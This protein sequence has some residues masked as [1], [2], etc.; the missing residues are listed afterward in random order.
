[1]KKDKLSLHYQDKLE[2]QYD[3]ID[4]FVINGYIPKLQI[5]GGFRNWYRDFNGDDKDLTQSRLIKFAGRFSRRIYA[6]AQKKG[7]PIIECKAEQRKHEI[8]NEHLPKDKNSNGLFLILKSRASAFIWEI[9]TSKSGSINIKRKQSFVNHYFFHIMDEKWGHV[10]I[11]MC[12]HPPFN[13]MIILNGHE[14]TERRLVKKNILFEKTDNCFTA[15]D[16]GETLTQVADTCSIGQLEGVCNRWI[17]GCLWFGV[18]Y[19]DQQRT[20]LRYKYSIYQVEYSRN[21]LF[22]R[23]SELDQVY[24]SVIDQTR[25]NLNVERIKTMFGKKSRPHY[26][27]SGNSALQ[28]RIEIPDYNLTVFKIHFGALTLKL[29]DKGERTLRAEVVVHNTKDLKCKRGLEHF[30]TICKKLKTIMQSFLD[31]L[32][33][34]HVATIA[35]EELQQ[36][37]NCQKAGKQKIS[38]INPFKKMDIWVMHAVMAVCFKP[39]GF[40]TGDVVQKIKKMYGVNLKSTQVAYVLRKLKAKKVILSQEGKRKYL[41]SPNGL[42]KILSMIVITEQQLPKVLAQSNNNDVLNEP[43]LKKNYRDAYF[44]L[45]NSIK[46]FIKQSPI[47]IAA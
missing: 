32:L 10:T 19:N 11:R 33:Y 5:P 1:M 45:K 23:G 2:D 4:R 26:S 29:Y 46:D 22:K 37:V 9:E 20:D 27:K 24:Q 8:A 30:D 43:T 21:L 39:F 44:Q 47:K 28:V 36:M 31:N 38:G 35:S 17:S 16:D 25:R 34:A 7:I 3:C 12:S 13:C 15:Y 40:S 6:F 41:A 18:D 42:Q 14:F